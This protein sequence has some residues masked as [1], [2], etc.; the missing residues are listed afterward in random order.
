MGDRHQFRA[1]WHDYNDGSYFITL[2]CDGGHHYFGEIYNIEI[3]YSQIGKIVTECIE[4]IP[5]HNPNIEV[6]KYVVMPNHIHMI[7]N[8]SDSDSQTTNGRIGCLRHPCHDNPCPDFHYNSSLSVAI[9]TF[10]AACTRK[11]REYL[12]SS[13]FK[14]WQRNYY[15]TIIRDIRSLDKIIN[16]IDTNIENWPHDCYFQKKSESDQ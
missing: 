7:L 2:C 1:E 3:V 14:L 4:E 8:I 5:K 12:N 16:Y 13:S 11:I 10:K 15:E 9:K 6:G